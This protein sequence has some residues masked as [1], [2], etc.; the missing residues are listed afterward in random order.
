LLNSIITSLGRKVHYLLGTSVLIPE[1]WS[2]L[3][4]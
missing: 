4:K 1:S 2:W 3:G